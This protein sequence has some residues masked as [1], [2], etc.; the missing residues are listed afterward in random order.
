[1]GRTWKYYDPGPHGE[2][3]T[4]EVTDKQIID[5]YYSHWRELGLRTC[6]HKPEGWDTYGNC[7]IDFVVIN[8]ASEVRK[9]TPMNE[10]KKAYVVVEIGWGYSDEFYTRFE[11][12]SGRPRKVFLSKLAAKT[13]AKVLNDKRLGET[14]AHKMFIDEYNRETGEYEVIKEY[15]EV[16]EVELA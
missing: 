5:K 8:W 2:R 1:M 12:N 13:E 15:Y 16:V 4:V 3:I 7:I 9:D 14:Y 10:K 6:K 11:S